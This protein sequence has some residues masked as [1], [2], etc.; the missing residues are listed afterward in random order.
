VRVFFFLLPSSLLPPPGCKCFWWCFIV[1]GTLSFG[2]QFASSRAASRLCGVVVVVIVAR[3]CLLWFLRG[4]ESGG[5][6]GCEG[7]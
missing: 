5:G 1:W 4:F 2:A 3:F 7:F 6:G